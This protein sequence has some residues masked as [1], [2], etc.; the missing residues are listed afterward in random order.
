MQTA[1][2]SHVQAH[3]AASTNISDGSVLASAVL[4]LGF[5]RS[6]TE[7]AVLGSAV[8]CAETG[9]P[10]L[11]EDRGAPGMTATINRM[12]ADREWVENA[13]RWAADPS[14]QRAAQAF[15]DACRD[16][17]PMEMPPGCL[18][19]P[20]WLMVFQSAFEVHPTLGRDG[21]SSR[22]SICRA[23]ARASI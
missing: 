14:H 21:C 10:R 8:M 23:F 16:A 4:L 13:R 7:L 19:D 15:L 17:V 12:L 11:P 20:Q 3:D 5:C 1:A 2:G 6:V 18:A 22:R 9:T